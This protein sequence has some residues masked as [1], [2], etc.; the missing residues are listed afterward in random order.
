M[1]FNGCFLWVAA[2]AAER[3]AYANTGRLKTINGTVYLS[4]PQKYIALSGYHCKPNQREE[5]KA[6]RDDNTRNLTRVTASGTKTGITVDILGGLH[7]SEKREIISWFTG[8]ESVA[9]QRKISL[10]YYD[11]DSG[12]YV[13]GTFYRSDIEFTAIYIDTSDIIWDAFTIEL[14]EY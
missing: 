13:S 10:L 4:F 3:T 1:A 8:H 7:D 14:V 6:Y 2:S 11:S 9:L 5:I 12:N